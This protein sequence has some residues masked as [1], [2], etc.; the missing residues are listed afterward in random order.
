[1]QQQNYQINL[2]TSARFSYPEFDKSL[3]VN[4]PPEQMVE[5]DQGHTW[6]RDRR[7]VDRLLTFVDQR[8]TSKPFMTF[9]FFESPHANY[10]FPE[11]SVIKPDYLP[12]FSYASMDLQRDIGGIYNRYLNSVHHLDSQLARITEHLEKNGLLDNTLVVITGD[13][14]EEFME[15]GRWG[16]NST[17]VDE[18]VRV[19]LVL[20]VPGRAAQQESL[21][22]SH[23]DLLPTLLP[24]LGVKN[25]KQDYSIGRSLF[26]AEPGRLLLAGD[27]D[28]LAFLGDQYKV[29]VPF[30]SGSFTALQTSKADDNLLPDSSQVLQN[31]LPLIQN[32]IR[33]LRRF[34]AH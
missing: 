18:Q 16:H 10:D 8:D 27:W 12:D 31:T 22:T 23:S 14:G 26:D 9:L 20:W 2:F 19:P 1:M 6:E 33:S 11:E 5:D 4:V 3:F 32:E 24:L 17:F 13:H 25:P 30:T 7:N 15:Q 21:R 28:R 34:L 29:V